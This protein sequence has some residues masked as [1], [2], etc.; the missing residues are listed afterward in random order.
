MI[1]ASVPATRLAAACKDDTLSTPACDQAGLRV[2]TILRRLGGG[3][4]IE[5][6]VLR[7]MMMGWPEVVRLKWARSSGK[8]QGRVLLMPMPP[9]MSV[10]TM[11]QSAPR[12]RED[13]DMRVIE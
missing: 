1:K 13:G 12:S 7:P 2:M 9:A 8:C 10:A 11:T 3:R 5:S 4:P 6:K